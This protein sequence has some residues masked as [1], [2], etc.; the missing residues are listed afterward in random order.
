[1]TQTLLRI[2]CEGRVACELTEYLHPPAGIEGGLRERT[3][4]KRLRRGVALG[5]RG[6][7]SKS[8]EGR[9]A[10]HARRSGVGGPLEEVSRLAD[11]SRMERVLRRE[12]ASPVD[13][14]GGGRRCQRERSL[15][16]L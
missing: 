12:N 4:V 16:E 10:Q 8:V 7:V 6:Q 14:V 2:A 1:M 3:D 9:G 11:A 15:G 13:P 5:E